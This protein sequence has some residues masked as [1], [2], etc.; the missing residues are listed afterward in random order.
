[1]SAGSAADAADCSGRHRLSLA[2]SGIAL[3]HMKPALLWRFSF[4]DHDRESYQ[5]F[6][7]PYISKGLRLI[8]NKSRLLV[9][10]CAE[11]FLNGRFRDKLLGEKL[12]IT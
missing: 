12:S 2:R 6:V 7:E 3:P 10:L 4:A 8:I 9:N 11:P 1:L 5:L